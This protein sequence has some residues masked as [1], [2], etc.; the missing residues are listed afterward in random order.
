[1][2]VIHEEVLSRIATLGEGRAGK[3]RSNSRIDSGYRPRT[4]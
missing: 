2:L 4:K 1:M 3:V